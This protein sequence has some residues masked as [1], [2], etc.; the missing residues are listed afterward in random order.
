MMFRAATAFAFLL[1]AQSPVFAAPP[2]P[3]TTSCV[4]AKDISYCLKQ[5]KQ[6]LAAWPKANTGDY[7][8]QRTIAFCLLSGCSEAVTINLKDAC[9]W[10]TV[11]VSTE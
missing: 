11:I 10:A 2:A 5:K 8:A 9:A 1:L 7:H 4:L 3:E 6:F